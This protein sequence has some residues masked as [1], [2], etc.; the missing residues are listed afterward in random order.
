MFPHREFIQLALDGEWVPVKGYP[1]GIWYQELAGKLTDH[2]V[3]VRLVKFDAGSFTTEPVIHDTAEMVLIFTGDLIVG[4]NEKGE[5]GVRYTAPTFAI[6]PAQVSHGPFAS[7]DGCI[8]LE[9]H[10]RQ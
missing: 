7:R 1:P 4:S 5:G 10:A 9:M 8:M 3:Q 6:R 2:G